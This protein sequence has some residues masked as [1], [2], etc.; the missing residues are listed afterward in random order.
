MPRP[1]P[2][3]AANRVGDAL[4]A[5]CRALF[6][7]CRSI[8]GPGLRA[9]L[10][11]VAERIPLAIARG[12]ER[13]AGCW[14]GTCRGNGTPRSAS[15][16]RLNG[17]TVV[18]FARHSLHLLQYSHAVDRVVPIEELQRHLHSLPEQPDL[19]PYRTAYYSETWGFCLPHRLREG[20]R[21]PSYQVRIDADLGAG[22]PVLWRMR[23]AGRAGGARC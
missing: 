11:Y 6:P 15:I 20:L 23:A 12:A 18:D 9:T 21:D 10:R 1:H 3:P 19:I 8:T 2:W 13:H 5:H 16:R 17:E 22:R 14:T 7:I 4:H